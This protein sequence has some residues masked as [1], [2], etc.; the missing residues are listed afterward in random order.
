M[1]EDELAEYLSHKSSII[2]APGVANDIYWNFLEPRLGAV[3]EKLLNDLEN[4][5]AATRAAESRL[6]VVEERAQNTIDRLQAEILIL[7]G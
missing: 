6:K 5:R 2:N 3:Q 7:R 4:A 1:L